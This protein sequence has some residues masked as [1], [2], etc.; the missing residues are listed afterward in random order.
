MTTK[1]K[2]K[3]SKQYTIVCR[4]SD[5]IMWRFPMWETMVKSTYNEYG[6]SRGLL[7]TKDLWVT[8]S[9]KKAQEV[10]R[11]A[12]KTNFL[13]DHKV[14]NVKDIPKIIQTT[15]NKFPEGHRLHWRTFLIDDDDMKNSD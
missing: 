14:V 4:R 7:T 3:S 9:F 5:F 11:W 12:N 8:D 6:I 2:K 10:K 13:C 1:R 15:K